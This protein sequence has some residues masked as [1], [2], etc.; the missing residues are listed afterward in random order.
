MAVGG[1]HLDKLMDEAWTK[2][3]DHLDF[4]GAH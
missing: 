4:T 3:E 1:G 2:D